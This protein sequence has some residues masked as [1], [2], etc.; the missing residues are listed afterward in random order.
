MLLEVDAIMYLPKHPAQSLTAR[1]TLTLNNYVSLLGKGNYQAVTNL[2]TKHGKAVSSS[3]ISDNA[4]HFYR[5]LFTKTITSPQ[6]KLTNIFKG[7]LNPDIM[8][9]L[10][11]FTWKNTTDDTVSAKFL[12]LVVFQ[13]NTAKIKTLY[14]FSNSFKDDIM[15]QLD[16]Q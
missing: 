3:G 1:R 7:E 13:E 2:F 5:T 14:V 8:T 12:D 16:S 10:F 9:V 11:D 15:K 4:P 6:S